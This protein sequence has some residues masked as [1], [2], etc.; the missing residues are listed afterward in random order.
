MQWK[1]QHLRTFYIHNIHTNL[2]K[3]KDH[4][5]VS[6]QLE[7]YTYC[8]MNKQYV[9]G[10]QKWK[11]AYLVRGSKIAMC[12]YCSLAGSETCSSCSKNRGKRG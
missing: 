9:G 6:Q 5:N 12:L 8:S 7:I 11:K 1:K 2:I 4:I 3:K 10:V